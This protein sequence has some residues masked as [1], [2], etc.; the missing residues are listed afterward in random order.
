MLDAKVPQHI[1]IKMR[2]VRLPQDLIHWLLSSLVMQTTQCML[3]GKACFATNSSSAWEPGSNCTN[4][5]AGPVVSRSHESLV[6]FEP[7]MVG[8]S[9]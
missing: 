7:S 9:E 8:L 1:D 2:V 5:L 6:G 4:D 3:L